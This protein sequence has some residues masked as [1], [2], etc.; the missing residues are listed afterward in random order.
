M[1]QR[2]FAS[3]VSVLC[4]MAVIYMVSALPF[5]SPLFDE[6]QKFHLDWIVHTVEYGILG[7]LLARALS[8]S[9]PAGRRAPLWAAALV[10][11]AL[12]AA[13]DEWHQRSVPTRDA[14]VYDACADTVGTALGAW[15]WMRRNK[16][17]FEANA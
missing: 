7:L 3:W 9:F 17:T 1:P 6:A 4:Y 8:N 16:R 5:G 15:A 14:S 12:Y 11:G 10:I 13:S 2:S